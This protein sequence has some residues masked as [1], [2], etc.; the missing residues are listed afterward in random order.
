MFVLVE[1]YL[2]SSERV[3]K[4]KIAYASTEEEIQK[5]KNRLGAKLINQGI[6]AL[7]CLATKNE[8]NMRTILLDENRRIFRVIKENDK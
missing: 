1:Y 2:D 3:L 6:D 7:E 8:Q 4:K 5:K